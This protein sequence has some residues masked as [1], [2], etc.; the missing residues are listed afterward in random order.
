QFLGMVRQWQELFF[1]KRYSF[2]ELQNPNFIKIAEGFGVNGEKINQASELEDA[3]DRMLNH[4]GPYVLHV[5]V[6]KEENVFPM[7]ATGK[8]VD[9]IEY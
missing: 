5:D 9:E 2:V 7:I 6:V 3:I 8:A 4:N 1:D